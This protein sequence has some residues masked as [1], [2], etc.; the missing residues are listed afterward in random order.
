MEEACICAHCRKAPPPWDWCRG[1]GGYD[2]KLRKLIRRYKYDR[3]RFLSAP[4]A[5]MMFE[6]LQELDHVPDFDWIVAVPTHPSR[7][8]K[9]GYDHTLLLA[10]RLSRLTGIPVFKGLIRSRDTAPQFGLDKSE[11]RRNLSGAFR[12]DGSDR[13]SGTSVVLVDDV[14]TTG[15]TAE[16]ICKVLSKKGKVAR[17]LVLVA[18]RALIRI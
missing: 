18:A 15:A 1:W 5:R 14:L 16:E 2:G 12:L 10:K 11:R 4:L 3:C 8:R 17:V 6:C 9:R 13:L 7:R